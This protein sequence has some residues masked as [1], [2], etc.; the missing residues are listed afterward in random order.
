MPEFPLALPLTHNLPHPALPGTEF[1]PPNFGLHP[2]LMPGA[3]GLLHPNVMP[4]YKIPNFHAILSQYMGLNNLFGGYPQNL[5][6]NTQARCIV[7]K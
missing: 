2:S 5:S 3:H 1:W 6:I 4:N 7:E